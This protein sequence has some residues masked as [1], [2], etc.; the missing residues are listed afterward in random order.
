MSPSDSS[1]KYSILNGVLAFHPTHA[2]TPAA[3]YEG[4]CACNGNTQLSAVVTVDGPNFFRELV[5]L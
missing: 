4:T 5:S 2:Q 1:I 3:Q